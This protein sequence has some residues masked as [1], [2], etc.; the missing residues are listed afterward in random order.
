MIEEAGENLLPECEL[1]G[2]RE[3][4]SAEKRCPMGSE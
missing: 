1:L 4:D 3:S 2:G